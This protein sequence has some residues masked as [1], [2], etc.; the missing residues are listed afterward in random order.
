MAE[1]HNVPAN[2]LGELKK[3][4]AGYA[5]TNSAMSLADASKATGM[6]RT[7][8]SGNAKF[9][10]DLG[11]IKGGNSKQATDIARKYSRA[12]EHKQEEVAQKL[13]ADAV[14]QNEFLSGLVSTVRIRDGMTVDEF[15]KHVLYVADKKNTPQNRTGARTIADLL[16]DSGVLN[17][18][19]GKLTVAVTP[20]ADENENG[21]PTIPDVKP[22]KVDPPKPEDKIVYKEVRNKQPNVTI[23]I[24]LQIPE[25]DDPDV[26][27]RFFKA[28]K[29][30]LFPDD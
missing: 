19:D 1:K 3:I 7:K 15:T 9:L 29:D 23:N 6:Q 22:P 11:F 8:I 24:T 18:S 26:Y 20:P 2:S 12:V 5:S 30:N 4:V 17:E 13:L 10:V 21:E 25:V 16:V 14:K 27:D 28:M